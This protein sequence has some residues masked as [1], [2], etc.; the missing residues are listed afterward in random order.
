MYCV[1]FITLACSAA[2]INAVHNYD[3]T[4]KE[5]LLTQYNFVVWGTIEAFTAILCVHI[6][7]LVAGINKWR[8]RHSAT[9]GHSDSQVASL[10]ESFS[11]ASLSRALSPVRAIAYYDVNGVERNGGKDSS[12][13]K[14]TQEFRADIE[15]CYDASNFAPRPCHLN[16]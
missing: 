10:S 5:W 6:P 15:M 13:I 4:T 16:C 2:R 3:L 14:I 8:T 1:G 11:H 9:V 7:C 12:S